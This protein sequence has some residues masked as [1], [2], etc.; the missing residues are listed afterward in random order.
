M[1]EL[2][3]ALKRRAGL[4]M[5]QG[6]VTAIDGPTCSVLIGGS[7]VPVDGVQHLN[8]CAPVVDD[9]VWITS[10]G[11]DLWI[12]GTHG[13]PP[14][15]DPSRLPTFAT[16][17]TEADPVGPAAAVT[18][19]EG[20]AA[21]STIILEWDLPPEAM[22]R[23]W[24]V[25]EGTS[26]GF[27]PGSPILTT[28]ETVVRVSKAS[29]SGP[30]YYKVRAIN[31][32]AEA[33]AYVEVGPFTLPKIASVDLGP[34]SVYAANMAANA[35]DL[36]SAAVT[37]QI[38]AAKLADNA[39]TQAKLVDGIVSAAKLVDGAVSSAKLAAGAVDS[40]KLAAAVNTA[41]S[42][43]QAA[44]DAAQSDADTALTTAN[45]KNKVVFST[46]DASGT[47]YT[48]GDVWFK[49]SGSLIVAQWEFLAG[50]WAARTLDNAVIGNL[51]AG[52]LTAGYIDAAR[53]SAAMITGTMIAADTI[54]A[55]NVAAGAITAIELA[56]GAV[57]AGKI[58]AGTI[59]A[60]DV[61]ASTITG[62]KIAAATIAAGNIVADTITAAQIA[63]GTITAAEIAADTIVANNIAAGAI[64][65]TEIAAGAIIAGKIGAGAIV[66]NDIAADAIT[67]AKIA[68]GAVTADEIGAGA[69]VAG[70][71]A[72]GS[73]AADRIAAGAITATQIAAGTIT[74]A[75][76]NVADVQ[77]AVVTAAKVNALTLNAVTITGGSIA[78][79]NITGQTITGG[80]FQ[81]KAAG[82]GVSRIII[83][84]VNTWDRIKFESGSADEMFPSSLYSAASSH[85]VL[86]TI[87][88]PLSSYPGSGMWDQPSIELRGLA[89]SGA[90]T[91][92]TVNAVTTKF[93]GKV[94][95][96]NFVS[97]TS[98]DGIWIN[99]AGTYPSRRY[100]LYFDS[101][102]G[103]LYCR[104]DASTYSYFARSGGSAA[105]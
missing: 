43:A 19:L 33:S 16:Y 85:D 59:V 99:D 12:I 97:G 6:V 42:A 83:D 13:D 44:A 37:G 101:D 23:T 104:R 76:L 30:W 9:V 49:K 80:I 17:F 20:S 78:G 84:G 45:G 5:R 72:A 2:A 60:A 10:D 64:G 91:I 67:T 40:T 95:T 28:K 73:I 100:K 31:T 38:V 51:N 56:A 57:T 89:T 70:K 74:A 92:I 41:I 88:G 61:A 26:A 69:V 8:S 15:I 4:R 75:K 1:R 39:V 48:T 14:P 55:G 77:A 3:E 66:A 98:D 47:A 22:W 65:A 7:T 102:T 21:F 103:R 96:T 71:I 46:S 62:A 86:F 68:A 50:A 93:T 34:G 87:M 32:R 35:V 79:V 27:M 81:S 24:E 63:A 82:A 53:I 52:K 105:I 58:A 29:G 54:V 18:G 11:A 36:A 94:V 25:C 90:P